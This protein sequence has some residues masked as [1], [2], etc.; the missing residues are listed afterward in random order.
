MI[1]GE[2]GARD[3]LVTARGN[4]FALYTGRNLVAFLDSFLTEHFLL[5]FFVSVALL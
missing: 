1:E 5:Q 3:N 4:I 2:G